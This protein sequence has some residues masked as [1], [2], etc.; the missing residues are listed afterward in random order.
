MLASTSR[1]LRTSL[2]RGLRL[3]STQAGP[4]QPAYFVERT[5]NG[6]LPVYSDI[7]GNAV[8]T[9]IRRVKGSAEVS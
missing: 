6:T 5:A 2:V 9:V 4:A 3:N 1:I 7:R 8:R